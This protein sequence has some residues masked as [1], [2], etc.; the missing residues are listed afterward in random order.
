V[1][2]T[3]HPMMPNLPDL[4]AL[5]FSVRVSFSG[6]RSTMPD[7]K[8]QHPFSRRYCFETTSTLLRLSPHWGRGDSYYS[9]LGKNREVAKTTSTTS[10]PVLYPIDNPLTVERVKLDVCSA[11]I[12]LCPISTHH[13]PV[14]SCQL[15]PSNQTS[16][17][18]PPFPYPAVPF[19]AAGCSRARQR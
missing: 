12:E 16:S 8:Q 4:L 10:W 7:N 17:C 3:R 1:N 2:P 14:Q 6:K 18:R 19:Y 15:R 11:P 9:S 13:G 5:R